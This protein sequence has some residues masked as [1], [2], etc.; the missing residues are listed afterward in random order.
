MSLFQ[1]ERLISLDQ[2]QLQLESIKMTAMHLDAIKTSTRTLKTYMKQTDIDKV[3][4]KTII[5]NI[6][7]EACEVI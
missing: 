3:E 4:A 6:Y 7:Q 1:I 2:Q 5:K